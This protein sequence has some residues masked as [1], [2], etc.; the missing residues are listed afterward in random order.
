M[1][2]LDIG[3]QDIAHESGAGIVDENTEYAETNPVC[4]DASDTQWSR[5]AEGAEGAAAR[6][7]AKVKRT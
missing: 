4:S 1:P 3:Q 5:P 7:A 6:V 2:T